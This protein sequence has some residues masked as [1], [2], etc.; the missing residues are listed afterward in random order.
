MN[1]NLVNIVKRLFEKNFGAGGY[2]LYQAPA[3]VNIIGEH[4]DYNG[5]F[6]LPAAIDRNI[7]V[8]IRLNGTSKI[9]AIAADLGDSVTFD[10][11]SD[12][13]REMWARY[14]YGVCREIVPANGSIMGFDT[15]FGGDI[16]QGAGMSSSAALETAYAVAL[17]DLWT[18]HHSALRMANVGRATEHHYIGVRCGIMDQFVS[19]VGRA[20]SL[21][22]LDCRSCDF[23]YVPFNLPDH[24][25]RI[26]LVDSSVKH[27][28]AKSPYNRRRESC[29]TAVEAVRERH[30]GVS[31]LRD[32]SLE[33]LWEVRERISEEDYKRAKF[34]VEENARVEKACAVLVDGDFEALGELMYKSHKGLAELYEVSCEE[35][36]FLVATAVKYSVSGARQMGGGF[37]GCTVNLVRDEHYDAF[38]EGVQRDYQDAFGIEC[39]V[40]P[41]VISDGASLLAR[42]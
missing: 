12:P 8:A 2:S 26:V 4:T 29:E 22:E 38:V 17:N 23:E 28:L 27:S 33:W 42:C 21:I 5:G 32:V 7:V 19:L 40:Y 14:I 15:V 16:P 35:S 20:D 9:R 24:G 13:P 3:R 31:C 11:H 36:D 34:V 10:V 39:R 1:S 25:Y 41:V 6:V 30:H 37:G 18:L